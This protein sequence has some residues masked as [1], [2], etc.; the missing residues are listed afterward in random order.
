MAW[1]EQGACTRRQ[2][3]IAQNF[4]INDFSGSKIDASVAELEEEKKCRDISHARAPPA[5]QKGR[6]D[7]LG[8][9][10]I[11]SRKLSE[12]TALPSTITERRQSKVG[13]TWRLPA[14]SRSEAM[15]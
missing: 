12:S 5:L 7:G 14:E 4:P 9:Q 10:I 13:F 6:L 2:W 1:R 11:N 3:E 8:N 15:R